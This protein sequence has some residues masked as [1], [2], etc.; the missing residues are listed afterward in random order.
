MAREDTTLAK[1]RASRSAIRTTLDEVD[2]NLTELFASKKTQA[3]AAAKTVDVTLTAA[4]LLAGIVTVNQG[5][6]GT[7]ALTL[8]L[9]TALDSAFADAVANDAFDFSVIN[10]STVAA[11]DATV[12]TNT[13]WT[14]VGEMTVESNDADRAR[15]SGL[16]RA[17][18]TGTGAWTLY[19]IA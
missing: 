18:K 7:S 5:A 12:T 11:E 14:L 15:S 9:A 13:G 16:F 10:I 1:G 17:R 6:A 3:A 8:P 19:R 2:R 4:E